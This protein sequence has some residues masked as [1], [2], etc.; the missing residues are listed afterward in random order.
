MKILT[1]VYQPDGG[2]IRVDGQPVT[3]PTARR[4]ALGSA[5]SIRNCS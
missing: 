1:G 4:A 2:E 5:S 3:L